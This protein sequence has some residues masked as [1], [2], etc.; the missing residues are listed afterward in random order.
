V[1]N[2]NRVFG[3]QIGI[4]VALL[5]QVGVLSSAAYGKVFFPFQTEAEKKAM[6]AEIKR[7]HV[8]V[9]SFALRM[10]L[11]AKGFHEAYIDAAR[12]MHPVVRASVSKYC[13]K[14]NSWTADKEAN[15]LEPAER[16]FCYAEALGMME[17]EVF[18]VTFADEDE[19]EVLKR[20]RKDRSFVAPILESMCGSKPSPGCFDA[21]TSALHQQLVDA[22][23][24]M[25]ASFDELARWSM[26]STACSEKT[27]SA[28]C[29]KEEARTKAELMPEDV[30][31]VEYAPVSPL[32]G[33]DG[34]FIERDG[35]GNK[36]TRVYKSVRSSGTKSGQPAGVLAPS[37]AVVANNGI[38]GSGNGDGKG[39]DKHKGSGKKS[40]SGNQGVTSPSGVKGSKGTDTTATE[41]GTGAPG[42][43]D[44]PDPGTPPATDLFTAP[45]AKPSDS[46]TVG[47]APSEGAELIQCD[48]ESKKEYEGYARLSPI[49]LEARPTIIMG[50]QS[51]YFCKVNEQFRDY[52]K[53]VFL[54]RT[55]MRI[56]NVINAVAFAEAI[57]LRNDMKSCLD[58]GFQAKF[59]EELD[60]ALEDAKIMQTL[61][62]SSEL[63]TL[64][65][66]IEDF[67]KQTCDQLVPLFSNAAFPP[68]F[69]TSLCAWQQT[70][71]N[72]RPGS[73]A[74]F[75][76]WI[77]RCR[78]TPA[79][80]PTPANP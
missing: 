45:G 74:G 61:D 28:E 19:T 48:D 38:A 66:K 1:L 72:E 50:A 53:A 41:P 20:L 5:L 65:K 31:K 17:E 13:Q 34:E 8:S 75:S 36:P 57:H 58:K 71:E 69:Q 79:V 64:I 52:A 32:P 42:G 11:H 4:A 43:T 24:E 44:V 76:R 56:S 25:S 63:E 47:G 78:I 18:A 67:G 14:K 26:L 60:R 59:H 6:E 7:C 73:P 22:F 16:T 9:A 12:D 80:V 70:L 27:R 33:P 2:Q 68:D 55:G 62:K 37:N 40:G 29:E 77:A 15:H 21:N 30:L 46:G 49:K 39:G 35:A 54:S 10:E 23:N 51:L 3:G